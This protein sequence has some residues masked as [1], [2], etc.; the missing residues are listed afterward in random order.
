M[1]FCHLQTQ[2]SF[3]LRTLLML[4]FHSIYLA[5]PSYCLYFCTQA[6]LTHRSGNFTTIFPNWVSF[7][8]CCH[9]R[10]SI[11][12]R[13]KATL[14][15]TSRLPEYAAPT[16]SL[17]FYCLFP[18]L[19]TLISKLHLLVQIYSHSNSYCPLPWF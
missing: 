15:K 3:L 19:F 2:N 14:R 4:L 6:C 5:F 11:L 12:L 10:F 8:T 9:Y 7:M 16:V 18:P 17:C 1:L 13:M